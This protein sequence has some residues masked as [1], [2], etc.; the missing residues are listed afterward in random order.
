VDGSRFEALYKR[1]GYL[2][3]RR[4]LALLG[5]PQ[6]ADDV[7]QEVFA[8]L[9]KHGDGVADGALLGWL[10]RVAQN[11]CVDLL[12]KRDRETQVDGETLARLD[13]RTT[14]KA[15]DGERRAALALIL[16]T[17]DRKSCEI[18][19]LHFLDGFTQE[20]IAQ[21]LGCSRRTVGKR[22]ER[23]E[24]QLRRAWSLIPSFGFGG[25]T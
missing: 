3:H 6:E 19:I 10:Y 25:S 18:A 12:R 1:Y 24:R 7:L 20:E 8:R 11:C 9:H 22:L 21:R 4:C 13:E 17:L 16:P 14:G 2:V 5:R 23:F 15:G